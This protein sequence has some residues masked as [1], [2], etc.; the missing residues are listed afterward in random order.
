MITPP[1]EDRH[2]LCQ[3]PPANPNGDMLG[4][5]GD[6]FS[7]LLS[8]YPETQLTIGAEN[9]AQVN[10][11][12]GLPVLGVHGQWGPSRAPAPGDVLL[13]REFETLPLRLD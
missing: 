9:N 6:T 8:T 4:A 2:S 1:L 13:T 10:R 5:R 3:W 7:F 11:I 12:A